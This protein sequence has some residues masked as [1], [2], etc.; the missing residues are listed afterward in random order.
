MTNIMAPSA[1]R[2]T[3]NTQKMATNNVMYLPDAEIL[4]LGSGYY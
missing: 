3:T 4:L 2:L 1:E